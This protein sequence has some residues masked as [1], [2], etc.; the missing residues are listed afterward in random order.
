MSINKKLLN[1]ADVHAPA[2]GWTLE[3]STMTRPPV[4][5]RRNVVEVPRSHGSRPTGRPPVFGEPSVSLDWLLTSTPTAG[6]DEV[7]AD[8]V[9]VLSRPGLLYGHRYDDV[10]T[11]A[12]AELVSISEPSDHLASRHMK[13]SAILA[14]PG[15]FLR[16][17]SYATSPVLAEGTHDLTTWGGTAPISDAIVRFNGGALDVSV[18]DAAYG[19]GVSWN[20]SAPIGSG[21]YLYLDPGQWRAWSSTS[22]SQWTPGGTDRSRWLDRPAAGRLQLWPL[23]SV[24]AAG[25]VTRVRTVTVTGGISCVIRAKGAFL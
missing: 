25:Q 4:Q 1:G 23:P 15:V 12:P 21:T 16:S 8:L 2:R 17:Q 11:E 13:V 14:L 3:D 24:D 19:E 10:V 18:V 22:G 20:G 5:V 9:S 6:L 7:Y